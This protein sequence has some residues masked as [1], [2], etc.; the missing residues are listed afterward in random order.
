MTK[1]IVK[2]GITQNDQG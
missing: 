2:Y 1:A